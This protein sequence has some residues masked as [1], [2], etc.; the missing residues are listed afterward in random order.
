MFPQ[1][2][3]SYLKLP[4]ES[5]DQY[6]SRVS[7]TTSGVNLATA[8]PPVVSAPVD[9]TKTSDYSPTGK[10]IYGNPTGITTEKPQYDANG[11]YIPRP[12]TG[13]STTP[14]GTDTSSTY[15]PTDNSPEATAN[16]PAVIAAKQLVTDTQKFN[17][18][19]ADI[20]NGATPLSAG[21]QAQIDGLNQQY[22]QMVQDQQDANNLA[23]EQQNML[24]YRQGRTQYMPGQHLSTIA[25]LAS[26]GATK[27]RA[28]QVEQASKVAV[29]TQALKDADIKAAKTAFDDTQTAKA[30]LA[31]AIADHVAGVQKAIDKAASDKIA[32]DKVTYDEVTKPIEDMAKQVADNSAP[33]SVQDAVKNAKTVSEAIAAGAGYF[34]DPTTP[35]GQYQ[36]YVRAATKAGQ[37]PMSPEAFMAKIKYDEAYSAAR[38]AAAGKAAGDAAA[39]VS[40]LSSLPQSAQDK[41]KASGFMGKSSDIQN[42]AI[43][44]VE[45]QGAPSQIKSRA[46]YSAIL[47]AANNYSQAVYNKPFDAAKADRDYKYA[48]NPSTLNTLKFIESLVGT[49]DGSGT[50]KGGN[51]D[52]NLDML[53][54]MSDERLSK[55]NSLGLGLSGSVLGVGGIP[56]VGVTTNSGES[57]LP[58]LNNVNQWTAINTGD[59]EMASYYGALLEVSDQVAKILQ[60]GGTGSTTSDAKLKEAQ[61]LFQTGFTPSQVKAVAGTMKQLIGNRARTMVKGNVYLND[62]ASDLGVQTAGNGNTTQNN[63]MVQ[64]EARAES[65][66]TNF[67]NSSPQN[68][69]LIEDIHKQFPLMSAQE[70]IQKLNII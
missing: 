9:T 60:G 33:Q 30:G 63:Q 12:N 55:G 32:A 13:T 57:Q 17:Q 3:S 16:D 19:Q 8:K 52:G 20:Q 64:D 70:V 2:T 25:D 53:V 24:D 67:Y 45:G 40:S 21:E 56:G 68:Q 54:A 43:Q 42:N 34:T 22:A 1:D 36:S 31:K 5:I 61:K 11:N 41:L 28:L 69:A 65:K 7:G 18:S 46:D 66:I 38:G 47:A 26:K 37:T 35:A 10:D 58:A 44:L 48:N 4:T 15:K 59:P 14:T 39:M 6:N 27:I 62:Y 50:L 49:D 29:L 23:M 51:P